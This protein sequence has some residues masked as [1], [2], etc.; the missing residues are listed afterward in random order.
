MHLDLW[1]FALQTI[2]V[3][4]LVWLL[5]RFL[6]RPIAGIIAARRAA[7]DAMLAEAAA[8]R[9]QATAEAAALA[10]Q[11]QNLSADGERIVAT[12]RTAAEAERGTIVH[13]AE[14]AVRK[15]R[16]DAEQGIAR[17]RQAMRRA[18]E[19]D[20]ADVALAIA[21][22]LVSRLPAQVLNHA[23]LDGLAE[24]IA[25]HPAR[26]TIAGMPIELRSA[27][28]LD[29]TAQADCRAVLTR[30]IGDIPSLSFRAD[31]TLVAGFELASPGVV[32]RNSW[33]AD[34]DQLAK[35]LHEET[36]HV[37]A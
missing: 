20:A 16:D 35:T 10:Q 24:V 9:A 37:V 21:K 22:R 8:T 34:L 6:F 30:L 28:P 15:L 7:A 23:F 13:Q 33:R 11:R 19:H 12:A 31:P 17:E 3:L 26:A 1:T 27:T 29:A 14:D 32:I 5:A 36:S 18:L 2:N 4:V 25:T